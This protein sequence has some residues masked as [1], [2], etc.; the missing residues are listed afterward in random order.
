LEGRWVVPQMQ[1]DSW[2]LPALNLSIFL[3]ATACAKITLPVK[4]AD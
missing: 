3:W 4:H 2:H 1:S